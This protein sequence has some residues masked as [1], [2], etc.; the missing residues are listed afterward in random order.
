MGGLAIF[1]AAVVTSMRSGK[2]ARELG[3]NRPTYNLHVAFYIVFTS[4]GGYPIGVYVI[5]G[6]KNKNFISR[7]T[8]LIPIIMVGVLGRRRFYGFMTRRLD[9]DSTRLQRCA[10]F[11]SSLL[12][13]V[14]VSEGDAW[15][16]HHGSD[17]DMFPEKDPR[18]NFKKGVVV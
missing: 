18:R 3:I 2:V 6:R 16:I 5:A 8:W 14:P 13:R 12:D 7:L 15:W 1:L 4:R 10:A 17:C 11:V 9:S